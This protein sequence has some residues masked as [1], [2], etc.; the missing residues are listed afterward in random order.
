MNPIIYTA[1]VY[2]YL[3]FVKSSRVVLLFMK[4]ILIVFITYHLVCLFVLHHKLVRYKSFNVASERFEYLPNWYDLNIL[5]EYYYIDIE[6]RYWYN[7][8]Y[9]RIALIPTNFE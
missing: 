5:R 9:F 3:K 4:I 7:H 8:I 6:N 1:F 2:V